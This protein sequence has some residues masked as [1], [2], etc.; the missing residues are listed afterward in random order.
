MSVARRLPAALTLLLSV[1]AA[2]TAYGP[3]AAHAAAAKPLG[4]A[5]RGAN[6]EAPEN[7]LHAFDRAFADGASAVETDVQFDRNN[8]PI[9][10]HDATT[11]RTTNCRYT[12]RWWTLSQ[13]AHCN[14]AKGWPYFERMPSMYEQV[15]DVARHHG[16]TYVEIKPA[17]TA[18]QIA[19]Y[20]DRIR[21]VNGYSWVTAISFNSND[22]DLVKRADPRIKTMLLTSTL[23]DL[24]T[25]SAYD[26]VD[27]A[28]TA[29]TPDFVAAAHQ[30]GLTVGAWTAD[31]PDAWASLTAMG[32]DSI[33]TNRI[34]D[35]L[36]WTPPDPSTNPPAPAPTDSPPPPGS[37]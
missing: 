33:T 6:T 12:I 36:A 30:R 7:T 19:R 17:A 20:V 24:D 22:L 23:P 34:R 29:L 21:W 13:M 4:V 3:G 25:A 11:N 9:I 2:A 8:A 5:H 27:V 26:G 10:S 14:A 28:W 18:Y 16:M 37:A 31:T 32:V 15:Q 35:Y 1:A